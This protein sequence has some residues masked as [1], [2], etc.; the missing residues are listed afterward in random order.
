M[1]I[2]STSNTD[3]IRIFINNTLHVY[4]LKENLLAINS[5]NNAENDYSIQI[6]FKSNNTIFL[7]YD[8]K[9]KWVAVLKELNS[10][11]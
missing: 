5:F 4:I 9:Q 3:Y 6:N 8:N 11:L 1:N 2:T 10:K 7:Q